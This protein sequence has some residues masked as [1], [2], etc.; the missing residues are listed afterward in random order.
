MFDRIIS[1]AVAASAGSHTTEEA[2]SES[3]V[4]Q[5]LD[6]LCKGYDTLVD[7]KTAETVASLEAFGAVKLAAAYPDVVRETV[8]KK[9]SETLILG[10]TCA[11]IG[12][13]DIPCPHNV[14]LKN[15]TDACCV[16]IRDTANALV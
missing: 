6:I 1:E 15:C 16:V 9:V 7:A 5:A 14:L 12:G 8:G 10:V 13:K 11:V 4:Q 2:H 3:K